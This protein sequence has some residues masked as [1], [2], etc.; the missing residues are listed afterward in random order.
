MLKPSRSSAASRSA[1]Q[2]PGSSYCPRFAQCYTVVEPLNVPRHEKSKCLRWSGFS[3]KGFFHA[4]F[5]SATPQSTS[6]SHLAAHSAVS[7]FMTASC[8]VIAHTPVS[9]TVSPA[10]PVRLKSLKVQGESD[11]WKQCKH[12]KCSKRH[13]FQ[14][15]CN[16]Q[17]KGSL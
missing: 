7:C 17:I 10:S 4:T 2:G 11:S 8:N 12:V 3:L 1:L 9:S 6:Q 14:F 15:P 16:M 13:L 5:N